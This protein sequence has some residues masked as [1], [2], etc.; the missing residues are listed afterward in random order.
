M[1]RLAEPQVDRDGLLRALSGFVG[2]ITQMPPMHSALKRNGRPLY[3]YARAGEEV[4]REPRKILINS[5]QLIELNSIDGQFSMR[6]DCSKGTYVRVLAEDIG[7][8]LGCGGY[9][10]ALRRTRIGRLGI[11]EA[12][13]LETLENLPE[14]ERTR[15]LKPVD[16]LLEDIPAVHLDRD[17]AQRASQGVPAAAEGVKP[18]LCRL[19]SDAGRFLGIGLAGEDG[20]VVPKRM[21]SAVAGG[22]ESA[23]S[24]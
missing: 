12:V 1:E 24:P 9:L 14:S 16:A 18:G 2:A 8:A 17:Q 11:R 22:A 20:T 23:V 15:V 10:A 3:D 5:I 7:K 21:M 19:Y 4:V 6:L 13:G